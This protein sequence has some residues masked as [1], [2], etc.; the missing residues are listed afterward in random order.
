MVEILLGILFL[1]KYER[2]GGNCFRV[3]ERREFQILFIEEEREF[4]AMGSPGDAVFLG[5]GLRE[6]FQTGCT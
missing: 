6:L 1:N 3:N 2:R 5:L 4:Q